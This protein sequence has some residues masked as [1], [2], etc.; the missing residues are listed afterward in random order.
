M[1]SL[2]FKINR[3]KSNDNWLSL[4][5]FGSKTG[6]SCSI[7]E[8]QIQNFGKT[9]VKESDNKIMFTGGLPIPSQL[10][11]YNLPT[12]GYISKKLETAFWYDEHPVD[13]DKLFIK[14]QDINKCWVVY[15]K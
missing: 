11:T 10:F 15:E 8:S 7:K 13:E 1:D 6:E 12:S 4:E 5:T 2:E 3:S 9:W 14:D